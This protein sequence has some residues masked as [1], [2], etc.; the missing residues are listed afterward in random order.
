[1]LKTTAQS[2]TIQGKEYQIFLTENGWHCNCP[3]FIFREKQKKACKHIVEA[4]K[5]LEKKVSA[6]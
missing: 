1:M 2:Q 5:K 3:D 4:Y 6:L